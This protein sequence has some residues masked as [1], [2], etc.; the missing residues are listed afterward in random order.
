MGK[1]LGLCELL[2]QEY[3]AIGHFTLTGGC[4]LIRPSQITGLFFILIIV[5]PST[6]L[7]SHRWEKRINPLKGWQRCEISN[8]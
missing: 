5:Y 8:S 2:K 1:S 6:H 3:F 7:W 4:Q